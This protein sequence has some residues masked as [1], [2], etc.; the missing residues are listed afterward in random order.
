MSRQHT[1]KWS[2]NQMSQSSRPETSITQSKVSSEYLTFKVKRLNCVVGST[3]QENNEPSVKRAK[4]E[5]STLQGLSPDPIKLTES[6][7]D[8]VIMKWMS[9]EDNLLKSSELLIK[10]LQNAL[11]KAQ[12]VAPK[13]KIEL[14]QNA[15]DRKV[16][17]DVNTER[18]PTD[19]IK[20]LKASLCQK[21]SEIKTIREMYELELKKNH[22]KEILK[23]IERID[24]LEQENSDLLSTDSE[25]KKKIQE[26][27]GQ[28]FQFQKIPARIRR[29]FEGIH[30]KP[31]RYVLLYKP[32]PSRNSNLHPPCK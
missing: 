8:T 23:L 5:T 17:S 27:E 26:L 29:P 21:E 19:A 9:E 14:M 7:L 32:P 28:I 6:E 13:E 24:K 25:Q 12:P 11:Q 4:I 1:I 22:A 16:L 3:S 15:L 31:G 2:E 30:V 20:T 18:Q 10:N